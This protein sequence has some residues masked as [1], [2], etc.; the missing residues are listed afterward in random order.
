MPSK[1]RPHSHLESTD[2]APRSSYWSPTRHPA[3]DTSTLPHSLF[4]FFDLHRFTSTRLDSGQ[5]RRKRE[6]KWP[7]WPPKHVDTA[8]SGQNGHRNRLIRPIPTET[9]AET[10]QNGQR[11]PFFCFMWP[12]ERGVGKKKEKEK[13]DEKTPKKKKKDRRRIKVCNKRI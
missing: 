8:N 2:V 3:S 5:F 10:G 13:K 6:P 4:F 7:K 12:C 9:T 11:L 1:N